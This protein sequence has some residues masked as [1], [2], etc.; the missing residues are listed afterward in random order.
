MIAK[1]L[2]GFEPLLAEELRKLG[3]MNVI[4][5]IRNV[6]FEGD[7]GFMYK[8]NIALRTAIRILVPIASFKILNEQD[9]Y[10]KIRSINWEEHMDV[11]STF[12]INSTTHSDNFTHSHYVSLKC[13]DAIADYF[14]DNYGERPNVELDNPTLMINIHIQQEH[15]D[16]SLDSS[17]DALY[18]RGY[19]TATNIAPINEVFAAGLIMMTGYNGSQHFIDPMCGSGTML[20]EAA[21]IA[22]QIPANINRKEFGFMNW[23][24]YDDSLYMLIRNAILKKIINS[25]NKIIGFDKAPSAVIKAGNNIE[26]AG[27]SDFIE[28][29]KKDFFTSEKPVEGSTLLCFNPPYGER[30]KIDVPGFYKNIGDTLKQFYTDTD[31]WFITSDLENGL[32]NVGLRTSRKIKVFNGNLECRFVKYE[33]YSGTKKFN[34]M[35]HPL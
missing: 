32:K 31:A 28:V 2:F 27:L 6:S 5:G 24:N 35:Q 19:K 12:A 23:K 17:G 7:T 20:I 33:M 22:N 14:R 9:L 34:K 3:A 8:S 15:C 25:P 29:Q 16:V 26:N 21:M 18:K 13:K 10:K 30:L 11:K 4:E 1:T